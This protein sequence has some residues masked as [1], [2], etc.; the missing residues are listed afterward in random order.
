MAYTKNTPQATQTI[1]FTQPLIQDNFDF[2]ETG[3]QQEHNFNASGTGSD[4]YH[5]K[6]SMPNQADPGALPAGTNGQYYVSGGIPK[7]YNGTAFQIQLT[8]VPLKVLTGTVALNTTFANVD[9]IPANAVGNYW[10]FLK[11]SALAACAAGQLIT[12]TTDMYI[13]GTS[14][15]GQDPGM[16]LTN[17][18]LIFK[19][20]VD[21]SSNNGVYTYLITYSTP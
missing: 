15:S 10:I 14:V 19:A 9:T 16:S 21:S 20:K 3:L 5:L 11:G 12:T 4:M 6:V 7:F 2:L 1:A 17:A 13:S 8:N 18:G